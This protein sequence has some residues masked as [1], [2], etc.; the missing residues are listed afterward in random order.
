MSTLNIHDTNELDSPCLSYSSP[1]HDYIYIYILNI[2]IYIYPHNI[3]IYIYIYLFPH[4]IYTY[5]YISSYYIYTYI[6]INILILYIYIQYLEWILR[7]MA[8]LHIH[9][10]HC[11][12]RDAEATRILGHQVVAGEATWLRQGAEDQLVK[13]H[14]ST[15]NIEIHQVVL[16]IEL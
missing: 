15:I 3:Y 16:T 9:H 11:A 7:V 14:E 5:I 4:I 1:I 10:V 12:R 6:Y 2:Y 13:P 8:L